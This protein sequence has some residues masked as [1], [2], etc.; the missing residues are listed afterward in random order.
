[1]SHWDE[2]FNSDEYIYGKEPNAFV[3]AIFQNKTEN[4]EKVVLLAEGEGRNA[5]YLAQLGYKVTTYDMSQV[6]MK[7][8]LQLANDANVDIEANYGDITETN[9]ISQ[10]SFDYS[11]NIFGHVPD[12]GKQEMFNNL[13]QSLVS[14]GHSYFEFYSKEQLAYGTGGPK[15]ET[16]LYDIE[17][18]KTCLANLPVTIHSLKQQEI[19]R[20]EGSKHTGIGSIIQGHVEKQ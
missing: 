6:G 20:N 5:I 19:A 4:H 17:E 13:I 3:K 15:D 2:K 11:I 10:S 16:M 7:K 9:L 18:I 1:M 12:D 14:G 8:Q